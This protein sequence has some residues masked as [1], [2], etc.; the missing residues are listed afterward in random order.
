M[1]KPS[2]FNR[3]QLEQFRGDILALRKEGYSYRQIKE[4]LEKKGVNVTS[5]TV[6]RF[7]LKNQ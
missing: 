1:E 4:W 2:G 7:I 6:N 5:V 3:N